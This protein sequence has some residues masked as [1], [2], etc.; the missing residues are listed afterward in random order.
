MPELSKN[1][2]GFKYN[3]GVRVMSSP[4]VAVPVGVNGPRRF[5]EI[6]GAMRKPCIYKVFRHREYWVAGVVAQVSMLPLPPVAK[7]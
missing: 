1:R 2:G 5:N 7:I 4:T 6:R 3:S